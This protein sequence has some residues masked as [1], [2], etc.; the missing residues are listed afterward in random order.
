MDGAVVDKS[1]TWAIRRVIGARRQ[2][3]QIVELIGE[4]DGIFAR[5]WNLLYTH[6]AL[7]SLNGWRNDLAN[8]GTPLPVSLQ[9]PL[10]SCL[11]NVD[12]QKPQRGAVQTRSIHAHESN[13][14]G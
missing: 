3:P 10:L 4:R 6:N 7:S 11:T 13:D 12:R 9:H 14:A 8:G 2:R 5:R 1:L